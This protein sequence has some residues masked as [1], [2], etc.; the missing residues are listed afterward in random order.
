[1]IQ[2]AS[3]ILVLENGRLTEQGTA[4]ELSKNAGYLGRLT[5]SGV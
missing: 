1:L 5:R 3:R 2:Q 4:G